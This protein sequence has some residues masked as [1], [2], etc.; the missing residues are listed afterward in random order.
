MCSS[1]ELIFICLKK[2]PPS[3]L[4]YPPALTKT[5]G[6][7]RHSCWRLRGW[8]KFHLQELQAQHATL[9]LKEQGFLGVTDSHRPFQ[10]VQNPLQYPFL[11]YDWFSEWAWWSECCTLIGYRRGQNWPIL[12][13][14]DFGST[15]TDSRLGFMIGWEN[16]R[17]G[18]ITM[19]LSLKTIGSAGYRD[20]WNERFGRVLVNRGFLLCPWTDFVWAIS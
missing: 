10:T 12:C 20:Q 15:C 6:S 1:F 9:K 16:N 14:W 11:L 8:H 5:A 18:D 2:P 17:D 3:G 7:S 19:P 13:T 4:G